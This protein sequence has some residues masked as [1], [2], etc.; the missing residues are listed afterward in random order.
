[1]ACQELAAMQ[2][3]SQR[4]ITDDIKL[5]PD[6]FPNNS[7]RFMPFAQILKKVIQVQSRRGQ[8]PPPPGLD[9]VNSIKHTSMKENIC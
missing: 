6:K 8:N 4:T 3:Q 9:R 2:H 1:M 5:F 7:R